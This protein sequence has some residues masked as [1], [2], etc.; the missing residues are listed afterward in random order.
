M[1]LKEA[2][3]RF[4]R[5]AAICQRYLEKKGQE[6]PEPTPART[7][8]F[9]TIGEPTRLD[10]EEPT[11]APYK[12][13]DPERRS[14]PGFGGR[15]PTE[16]WQTVAEDTGMGLAGG[17]ARYMTPGGP[18]RAGVDLGN[19]LMRDRQSNT[20]RVIGEKGG[21]DKYAR[22]PFSLPTNKHG[23]TNM[24]IRANVDNSATP[25]QLL[26]AHKAT[27]W[28]SGAGRST[29]SG[30]HVYAGSRQGIPRNLDAAKSIAHGSRRL[31]QFIGGAPNA[32]SA[33]MSKAFGGKRPG[34]Q[35]NK[36]GID[37]YAK[38]ET[39]SNTAELMDASLGLME[40]GKGM[41]REGAIAGGIGGGLLVGGAGALAG[42]LHGLAFPGKDEEGE[43]RSRLRE[44]LKR[45][46]MV[47][48]PGA[49]LG[50]AGGAG[51]GY[52]GGS[53]MQVGLTG[54][55]AL[56]ASMAP[57]TMAGDAMRAYEDQQ[58]SSSSDLGE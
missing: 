11:T 52:L 56:G 32:L 40:A 14:A 21:I 5:T 49:A 25:E 44:V 1:K 19:T 13:L 35:L 31:G 8:Q 9:D 39:T 55:G 22:A 17:M 24:Q 45:A 48:I 30:S 12:F 16:F 36:G 29:P 33:E 54:M 37:K 42:G 18:L 50:G 26:G 34:G 6:V 2:S 38:P 4:G 27:P 15:T 7:A 51:L 20:G 10:R 58:N 57:A 47:G 41:P 46:L 53:L 3:D 23:L 28:G 43:E